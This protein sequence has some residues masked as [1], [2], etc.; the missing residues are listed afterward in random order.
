MVWY[1]DWIKRLF[2]LFFSEKAFS[3][4]IECSAK[5]TL[6]IL[7]VMLVRLLLRRAP[8]SQRVLL[9]FFVGAALTGFTW[10]LNIYSL[11]PVK[12]PVAAFR[13]QVLHQT[14]AAAEPAASAPATDTASGF[15]QALN[16]ASVPYRVWIAG[17]VV[18]LLYLVISAVRLRMMV[19]GALPVPHEKRVYAGKHIRT[20]FIA[21]ILF[22]R[23]YLPDDL[24]DPDRTSVL[25]HERAHL[26]RKDHIW[27]MCGYFVLTVHWFN[28]AV[29]LAYA[30]LTRDI[31]YAC[32]ERVIRKLDAEGKK[33]YAAALLNCS[34]PKQAVRACP[35]A[36][37]EVAVKTRISAVLTYRRPAIWLKLIGLAAVI[38]TPFFFGTNRYQIP[39]QDLLRSAV[40]HA[41]PVQQSEN[42]VCAYHI[43]QQGTGLYYNMYDRR[44][45]YVMYAS[46]LVREYIPAENGGSAVV[47]E[48]FFPVLVFVKGGTSYYEYLDLRDEEN[49]AYLK[50]DL[51]FANPRNGRWKKYY[52]ELSDEC[53]AQMKKVSPTDQN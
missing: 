20:P 17:I 6:L 18:M 42:R 45:P 24:A 40:M 34:L 2:F 35:L 22:P 23:I 10:L 28:P 53:D 12:E 44:T 15:L 25:L 19:R 8:K 26:R 37:G 49:Y 13:E 27:K 38:A 51:P 14:G 50:Y 32:D 33:R 4:L 29:W 31:E 21:G 39:S 16:S 43:M 46:A 36:F 3:M 47:D 11:Q 41:V 7:A 30:M 52:Q 48:T 5:C 1:I 9:W